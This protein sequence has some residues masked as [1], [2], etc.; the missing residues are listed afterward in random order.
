[1]KP[2]H[3]ERRISPSVDYGVIHPGLRRIIDCALSAMRK[4]DTYWNSQQP[5]GLIPDLSVESHA[6][7]VGTIGRNF[8]PAVG[9]AGFL[10][11]WGKVCEIAHRRAKSFNQR[12]KRH[13]HRHAWLGARIIAGYI[14]IV[15]AEDRGILREIVTLVHYHHQPDQVTAEALVV[16][17]LQLH[18]ID[19]YAS[20]LEN[21]N[22]PGLG[23]QQ[24]LDVLQEILAKP[25][26]RVFG[27]RPAKIHARLQEL[28]GLPKDL[29][30]NFD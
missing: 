8:S 26:Y 20:L 17:V 1:M 22:R 9:V 10:H 14:P 5:P 18:I 12:E 19:I 28:Y 30:S 6:I 21:R 15:R 7:V 23:Q 4:H 27:D 24:A 2:L 13:K 25:Y 29:R 11:D 3:E 16:P